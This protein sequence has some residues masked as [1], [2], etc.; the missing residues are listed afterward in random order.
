MKAIDL[1]Y[2]NAGG[3]HRS[4]AVALDTVIRELGLPWSARLVNLF[5]V[6]DPRDVFGKTTGM[7][8]EN[9]YNARLARG[10]T[11]GLSQELKILQALI[12]LSHKSL[13]LQLQRHW[14]KTQPDLVV[15][16][17]PNFNRAMYQALTASRPGVP[18]VTILTDFA[19]TPPHFWI[20][21]HQAQHVI[22]GTPKAVAQARAA[23]YDDTRVHSTSGMIIRPDFYQSLQFDRRAERAKLQLD[24]DRPTAMVMFGGHGSTVMRDI[25]RRLDDTQLI[26]VCGH[27]SAL[28]DELRAMPARAP[29]AV[30]GFS[31]QIRYFMQLSDFFIGKPGPG[32]ISEA[33]QQRLP[34]IVVRNAWTMPQ[35]RYNTEWVQEHNAG[36][37]LDSFKA[38][39]EGVAEVTGRLDDFRAAV[40]AIHNR[41]IFEIPDILDRI[42]RLSD[43]G[44][45][46]RRFHSAFPRHPAPASAPVS[47]LAAVARSGTAP[48]PNS[49]QG[50]VVP[51]RARRRRRV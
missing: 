9:Y 18:Y 7:K 40:A 20:E 4:A 29:R 22:C 21:P 6:L 25:A 48:P 43:A 23:G 37:V 12:R 14:Q 28:A 16:L 50:S 26:L 19:D 13:S 35:E 2:F 30:I 27:N 41:A 46:T 38:I 3:G 10:W 1:V 24:P 51:L 8:P 15:S 33:V 31:T 47:I 11:L 39:R 44:S 5:E 32:S 34:V 17:V 42:L 45:G 49:A 36:V